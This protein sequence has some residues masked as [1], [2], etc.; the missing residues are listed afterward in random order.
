MDATAVVMLGLGVAIL[1]LVITDAF[2]TM[3]SFR[4]GGPLS[5]R[6]MRAVWRVLMFVHD[7]RAIHGVLAITGDRK[8]VV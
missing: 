2:A 3:L 5:N 1:A 8:S 7:R 6:L 4:G